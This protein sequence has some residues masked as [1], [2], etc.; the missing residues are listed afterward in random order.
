M[1]WLPGRCRKE[2]KGCRELPGYGSKWTYSRHIRAKY[3][4]IGVFFYA[5]RDSRGA[6]A[7]GMGTR[8]KIL[9]ERARLELERQLR[10]YRRAR[11]DPRPPEGWLR[12]MR[13]AAG[14]PAE[15]I[16]EAMKFT[17]KMVFQTE[18]SEQRRTISLEQLGRMARALECDLVYGL[19]PFAGGSGDGTC[20]TGIV[21]EEVYGEE[22]REQGNEGTREQGG[23]RVGG[24]ANQQVSKS[25]SQR[26]A[27]LVEAALAIARELPSVRLHYALIVD[28]CGFHVG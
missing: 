19:A 2:T 10:P 18:R 3:G 28:A 23:R 12:A 24:L 9:R 26:A 17:T 20:G 4:E 16:A 22:D 14:I 15:R 8:V 5:F 27:S 7:K 21:E 6:L 25:A 11:R 13:L 1:V